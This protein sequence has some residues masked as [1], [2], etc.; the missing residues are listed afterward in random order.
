MQFQKML[1]F[2]LGFTLGVGLAAPAFAIDYH[3][4]FVPGYNDEAAQYCE[5]VRKHYSDF[6]KRKYK[7]KNVLTDC[8]T[9]EDSIDRIRSAL[10]FAFESDE[11]N[12]VA[13]PT[14]EIERITESFEYPVRVT[15]SETRSRTVLEWLGNQWSEREETY[16]VAIYQTETR[17]LVFNDKMTCEQAATALLSG[18]IPHVHNAF[19]SY[20][21]E[22]PKTRIWTLDILKEY[23]DFASPNS[24]CGS[25]FQ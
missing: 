7:F 20:C 24:G 3:H 17:S 5:S 8:K 4:V 18:T 1:R 15:V 2:Y 25:E 6:F 9:Y 14:L 16:E 21:F 19:G 23:T 11:A 13:L 12:K 22:D 10:I